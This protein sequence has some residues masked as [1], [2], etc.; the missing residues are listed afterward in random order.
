M[1]LFGSKESLTTTYHRLVLSWSLEGIR[2]EGDSMCDRHEA[3]PPL[4]GT[5]P[6]TIKMLTGIPSTV[7][8]SP[9]PTLRILDIFQTPMC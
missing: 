1:S 2:W 4:G 6:G 8:R 3:L 9:C 7:L 5:N